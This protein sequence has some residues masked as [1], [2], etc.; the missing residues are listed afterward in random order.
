MFELLQLLHPL[1]NDMLDFRV[2]D[3]Q[4]FLVKQQD[5]VD[6]PHHH[7][8]HHHHPSADPMKKV[9]SRQLYCQICSLMFDI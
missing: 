5:N 4:D 9:E 8:H 6:P 7:H 2:C 1:L 3:H